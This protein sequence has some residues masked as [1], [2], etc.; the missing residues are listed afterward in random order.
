MFG[1]RRRLTCESQPSGWASRGCF[2]LAVTEQAADHRQALVERQRP[3]RE[4]VPGIVKA[5]VLQSGPLADRKPVPIQVG[6]AD[7]LALA[8]NDMRVAVEP[9]PSADSPEAPKS[10]ASSS[11]SRAKSRNEAPPHARSS[12]PGRRDGPSDK[13][14]RY[15]CPRP[16][17]RREGP[18]WQSF[19][20]PA[21]RQS[22]HHRG[23]ISHRRSHLAA[24]ARKPRFIARLGHSYSDEIAGPA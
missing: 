10:S 5:H 11:R 16:P 21:A 8:R 7:P 4:R 15:A 12:R 18:I 9:A 17:R 19:A 22:R 2:H 20:P 3:R 24:R 13:V 1:R 6:Q 14:P 23:L